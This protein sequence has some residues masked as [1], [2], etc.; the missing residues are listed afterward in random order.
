MSATNIALVNNVFPI[1]EVPAIPTP[2]DTISPP[3]EED[4]EA[5]EDAKEVMPLN[6]LFPAK[7]W[8]P[9]VTVPEDPVPAA[10]K[11]NV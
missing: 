8:V 7:V 9:V 6:V 1:Y 10:G 2:P 11:L 4:V 3:V 5:V